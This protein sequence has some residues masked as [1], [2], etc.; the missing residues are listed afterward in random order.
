MYREGVRTARRE[1][2]NPPARKS[3]GANG[4]ILGVSNALRLAR[5][6]RIALYSREVRIL[7]SKIASPSL[8]SFGHVWGGKVTALTR[9]ANSPHN[10]LRPPQGGLR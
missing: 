10:G 3:A 7:Q 8:P 5:T 4:L 6:R 9:I 2:K 1:M